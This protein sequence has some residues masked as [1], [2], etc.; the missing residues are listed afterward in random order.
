MR[1]L[2]RRD[3]LHG[4]TERFVSR[5]RALLDAI[6]ERRSRDE[7]HDERRLTVAAPDAIDMRN[8]RMIQRGERLR[9]LLEARNAAGVLGERLRQHLDRDVT[10]EFG[11]TGAIN[12]ARAARADGLDDFVVTELR[13]WAD[14]HRAPLEDFES[15]SCCLDC[16]GSG[17]SEVT[18]RMHP[19]RRQVSVLPNL[20]EAIRFAHSVAVHCALHCCPDRTASLQSL[21]K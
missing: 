8:V 21:Q 7:F 15:R 14:G 9:F 12:L 3:D 5:Q 17:N 20:R 10:L 6:G 4:D 18:G 11:I 19:S 1:G 16:T 13:T 2:E